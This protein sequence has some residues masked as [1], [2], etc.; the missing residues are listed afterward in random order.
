MLKKITLH[1]LRLRFAIHFL[2]SGTDIRYIQELLGLNN[3][4][5]TMI[6]TH[7]AENAIKNIS[8]PFEGL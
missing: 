8:N 5:I 4:K 6:Y 2:E 7:V 1:T 3:P